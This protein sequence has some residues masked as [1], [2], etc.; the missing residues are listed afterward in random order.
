[1]VSDE[2]TTVTLRNQRL[3]KNKK[4]RLLT[5]AAPFRGGPRGHPR[6]GALPLAQSGRPDDNRILARIFIRVGERSAAHGCFVPFRT[7]KSPTSVEKPESWELAPI[8][9]LIGV[10]L[11]A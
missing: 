9:D 8:G 7:T 2:N 10:S 3:T 4:H 1:L 5:R 6:E 11:R